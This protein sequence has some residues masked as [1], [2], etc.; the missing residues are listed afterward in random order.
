[1][2]EKE[3]NIAV[4]SLHT[5][6]ITAEAIKERMFVDVRG[7][8]GQVQKEFEEIGQHFFRIQ[9]MVV[10]YGLLYVVV[11]ALQR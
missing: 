8:G 10:F 9:M 3:V 7:T 5:H 4:V 6:W 11:E 1:M 2:T